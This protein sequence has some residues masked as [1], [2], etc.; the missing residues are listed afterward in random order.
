MLLSYL[1]SLSL[2]QE[3]DQVTISE[4][5]IV[6]PNPFMTASTALFRFSYKYY[7]E[8]ADFE[9]PFYY[10]L[11]FINDSID[12]TEDNKTSATWYESSVTVLNYDG[13]GSFS[14][15][16]SLNL[17]L[18]EQRGN[19]WLEAFY[20]TDDGRT[21]IPIG[22]CTFTYLKHVQFRNETMNHTYVPPSVRLEFSTTIYSVCIGP[23]INVYA[24]TFASDQVPPQDGVF[25]ATKY[26]KIGLF[27]RGHNYY[28]YSYPANALRRTENLLVS[29]SDVGNYTLVLA[30]YNHDILSINYTNL[31]Y[32]VRSPVDINLSSID[33]YFNA[34]DQVYLPF[35]LNITPEKET[36]YFVYVNDDKRP[37]DMPDQTF[38]FPYTIP[39][40]APIGDFELHY[41][42]TINDDINSTNHIGYLHIRSRPVLSGFSPDRT[43]YTT[44][45]KS[46]KISFKCKDEDVGDQ[47]Q[48]LVKIGANEAF[49]P[50][51]ENFSRTGDFTDFTIVLPLDKNF[52]LGTTN[53]SIKVRDSYNLISKES[54]IPILLVEKPSITLNLTHKDF[55]TPGESF[56]LTL[57][58]T[59]PDENEN[60]S[61]YYKFDFDPEHE[62]QLDNPITLTNNKYEKI[63]NIT[64]PSSITTNKTKLIFNATDKY[65]LSVEESLDL[66]IHF[67]PNVTIL[68]HSSFVP[69]KQSTVQLKIEDNDLPYDN[70]TI[71][72]LLGANAE[73]TPIEDDDSNTEETEEPISLRSISNSQFKRLS[74]ETSSNIKEQTLLVNV[75]SDAAPGL[76]NLTIN[77]VDHYGLSSNVTTSVT[78]KGRPEIQVEDFTSIN[79]TSGSEFNISVTALDIDGDNTTVYLV[80]SPSNQTLANVINGTTFNFTYHVP[81]DQG[82]GTI[83]I[84]LYSVDTDGLISEQKNFTIRI[85]STPSF[86]NCTLDKDV[87]NAGENYTITCFIKDDD[88][89]D[90]ITYGINN[91]TD[92]EK[93]GDVTI[94]PDNHT[95][96]IKFGPYLIPTNNEPSITKTLVIKDQYNFTSTKDYII[97]LKNRPVIHYAYP[98]KDHY[99]RGE[100]VIIKGNITDDDDTDIVNVTLNKYG[101][102]QI[103]NT[104]K[105]QS[106]DFEFKFTLPDDAY[107]GNVTFIISAVDN[108]SI[109]AYPKEV[110]LQVYFTPILTV[111]EN[112]TIFQPGENATFKLE[113]E[114]QEPSDYINLSYSYDGVDFKPLVHIDS[115]EPNKSIKDYEIEL[116]SDQFSGKL[117]V[118]FKAIDSHGLQDNKSVEVEI[119]NKPV[120]QAEIKTP[121][122]LPNNTATIHL[123]ITDIDED[124]QFNVTINGKVIAT[125][126]K[127]G[128]TEVSFTPDN[129]T[130]G[131][132]EIVITVIDKYGLGSD[133]I[134][135]NYSIRAKPIVKFISDYQ[136]RYMKN[137]SVTIEYNISDQDIPDSAKLV[138]KIGDSIFIVEPNTTTNPEFETKSFNITIPNNI[139]NVTETLWLTAT[140]QYGFESNI[141]SSNISIVQ[142]INIT[143][144]GDELPILGSTVKIY[145]TIS[146]PNGNNSVNYSI[147]DTNGKIYDKN[148]IPSI[149]RGEFK[150]YFN[151]TPDT[152]SEII[153]HAEIE[154]QYHQKEDDKLKVIAKNYP[155][156]L[157]VINGADIHD[158]FIRRDANTSIIF[159]LSDPNPND[160]STVH[161]EFIGENGDKVVPP[162]ITVAYATTPEGERLIINFTMTNE[163]HLGDQISITIYAKDQS[164]Q[165]SI[166][167]TLTFKVFYPENPANILGDERGGFQTIN[168]NL[169]FI[170]IL[171]AA[172]IITALIIILILLIYPSRKAEEVD[173]EPIVKDEEGDVELPSREDS[174]ETQSVSTI[175]QDLSE[176]MA[177][178]MVAADDQTDENSGE[179]FTVDSEDVENDSN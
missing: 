94:T 112:T 76:T 29:Q 84:S 39:T 22:E 3:E 64:I 28:N 68:G 46:I 49:I 173:D 82:V 48:V 27:S 4:L 63:I 59:D 177:P 155:P 167:T 146:E 71:K 103:L 165:E 31:T 62:I 47:F 88:D 101:Q 170:I 159:N 140:D 58:I 36:P 105:D 15:Y 86:I 13:T 69:D 17:N 45:D 18:G 122:V 78:V 8:D 160:Y 148:T 1:F 149:E 169:K 56:N 141:A 115:F 102:P 60:I 113:V 114:E 98:D 11:A 89:R 80:S 116:P 126:T 55:Y 107:V 35:K 106:S 6:N 38:T 171:I 161:V 178:A 157:H 92:F 158:K 135:L 124:E 130:L 81:Q 24:K 118:T 74:L 16:I 77:V 52:S 174:G 129:Q 176:G 125:L 43:N 5:K 143:L 53:I 111:H 150:S 164:G 33:E 67:I 57:I 156:V 144:S 142:P 32:F 145:Y 104:K 120:I 132:H 95:K 72:Y 23:R 7:P 138:L 2:S 134:K 93:V 14:E 40:N 147:K 153:F 65:A 61:G 12:A 37:Y 109:P 97:N 30:A 179:T 152:E 50:F 175:D 85:R 163:T 54:I 117:K 133:P 70:F 41:N 75:S 26:S 25:D 21:K 73:L 172:F 19:Y 51:G 151:Y 66:A 131:E 34:G 83:N 108:F 168:R 99:F 9:Y 42:I 137:Q 44:D 139:T 127:N 162:N 90:T 136:G 123:N 128:T 166:R 110:T 91:G 87:Y 119:R 100:T 154:D 121:N 79:Y 96:E 10:R 20:S